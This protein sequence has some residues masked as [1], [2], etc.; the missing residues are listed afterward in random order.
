MRMEATLVE[1]TDISFTY[2]L[3]AGINTIKAARIILVKMGF[4]QSILDG[5]TK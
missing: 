4:P 3:L 5:F 2:K 1:Q